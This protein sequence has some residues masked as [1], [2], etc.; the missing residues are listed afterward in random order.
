MWLE[1][2]INCLALQALVSSLSPEGSSEPRKLSGEEVNSLTERIGNI[3][4]DVPVGDG[5]R[6][7]EKGE[8]RC[9]VSMLACFY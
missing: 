3:L 7:N 5:E 1:P 2:T 6:R 8:V 9:T 4:G